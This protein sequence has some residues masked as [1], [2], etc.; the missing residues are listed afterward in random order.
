MLSFAS[1]I[2]R[3]STRS[4]GRGPLLG[5]ALVALALTGCTDV[6]RSIGL[7]RTSPDEFTVVSR[8][9][10]TMPPSLARLPEPRP[11]AARPQDATSAAVAAASVFGGSSRA[12]AAGG[13]TAAGTAGESALIAQAGAK[14]GIEPGIR[15]KVDQE[16]TQLV[17]ADKSWIDSLLFWQTQEQPYEVVDPKKENQ[18]LREAQAT[19]KALNDGTV[20]TIERKR[21]APLEG[22]F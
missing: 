22:L 8:A 9:P 5:L 15:N 16:T 1:S 2:A 19:G 6:R 4:L 13:R 3:R 10:L 20:P 21:R 12:T 18:R 14:S 11:G 17:V 7:D